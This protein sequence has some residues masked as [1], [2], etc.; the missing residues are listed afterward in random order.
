MQWPA[1]LKDILLLVLGGVG[2]T[3]W[4]FW[5]RRAEQTPVF[6]NIQKAEKLLSL[7]KELDNTTYTVWT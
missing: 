4:F 7:R 6:E 5:R 1:M 2:T 3:V